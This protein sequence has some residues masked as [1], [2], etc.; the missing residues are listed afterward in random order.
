METDP[1]FDN[2]CSSEILG[3]TYQRK[4]RVRHPLPPAKL[5]FCD[6]YP[7]GIY[8]TLKCSEL[9]DP[10]ELQPQL[11]SQQQH[12]PKS[13]LRKCI[14]E[15]DGERDGGKSGGEGGP[16]RLHTEKTL[17]PEMVP[18]PILCLH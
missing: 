8:S 10:A 17:L 14:S 2:L 6:G 15:E 16:R 3:D 5:R 18:D 11:C 13:H 7:V 1:D 9:Q 4:T 12:Q